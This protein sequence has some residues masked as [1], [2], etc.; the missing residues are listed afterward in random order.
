[1]ITAVLG[2]HIRDAGQRLGTLVP[3]LLHS[4]PQGHGSGMRIRFSGQ[5]PPSKQ[6]VQFHWPTHGLNVPSGQGTGSMFAS[7]G[8]H[9]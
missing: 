5:T 2:G 4:Y 7:S 8:P 6:S 3:R 9:M 1:V